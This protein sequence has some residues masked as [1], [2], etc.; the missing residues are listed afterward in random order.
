MLSRPNGWQRIG[1]VLTA[2][3][4]IFVFSLGAIG[5][6][7]LERGHGPFV[8]TIHGDVVVIKK[9]TESRCTQKA[10]EKRINPDPVTGTIPFGDVLPLSNTAGCMP[11]H[12]I[13]GT[14]DVTRKLPD[15][16][17]FQ[18]ADMLGTAIIPPVVAWILIYIAVVVIRWV[19]EGFRR[20]QN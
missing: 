11:G 20:E 4:L 18:Y 19:M 7:S 17:D 14:P 2:L 1:V 3:W 10:P 6:L 5:Y 16:H 13:E 12:Y 8:L 9:G 15:K